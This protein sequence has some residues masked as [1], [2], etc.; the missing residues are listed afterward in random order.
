MTI[1]ID[2]MN[3]SLRRLECSPEARLW[4]VAYDKLSVP[5]RVFVSVWE[6]EAEV[7]NG[8]FQQ[9]FLNGSG[10]IAPHAVAALRAVRAEAMAKIVERAFLA[11]DQDIPWLNDVERRSRLSG[12]TPGAADALDRLDREFYAYPDNLTALLFYVAEYRDEIA[13]AAE[14]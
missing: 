5:E 4:Q 8:G 7:N 10:R 2:E 12:L 9:Y 1:D 13:G 11:V 6:L 3:Q 14:F